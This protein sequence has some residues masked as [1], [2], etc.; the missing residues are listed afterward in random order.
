MNAVRDWMRENKIIA[1]LFVGIVASLSAAAIWAGITG[2][3]S[4]NGDDGSA[5][6][7]TQNQDITIIVNDE[8][9]SDETEQTDPPPDGNQS[10]PTSDDQ[11]PDQ[12][13]RPASPSPAPDEAPDEQ[14]QPSS[15]SP[16]PD[17]Q[18]QTPSSSPVPDVPLTVEN[19]EQVFR[20]GTGEV[21]VVKIVKNERY[22]RHFLS[23]EI[24]DT[25]GH[26]IGV[27][28]TEISQEEFDSF[29]ISCLVKFGNDYY[30]LDVREG[31]DRAM[32]HLI[33]DGRQGLDAAGVSAAAIFEVH[34]KEINNPAFEPG[35]DISASEAT[36]KSCGGS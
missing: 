3:F 4:G 5:P 17:E 10:D 27:E 14:D 12:Q 21:Y 8:G 6:P 13:D 9:N 19:G 24:R 30:F 28:P 11:A 34:G 31:E 1:M 29:I 22:K 18:D 32:K 25:Y 23:A 15:P 33:A 16:A 20:P 35:G 2:R 26:L 7:P 36:R